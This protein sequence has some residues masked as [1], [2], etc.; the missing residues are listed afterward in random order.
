M[1]IHEIQQL[2]DKL[3]RIS[4]SL[5]ES[6]SNMIARKVEAIAIDEDR[7]AQ[8]EMQFGLTAALAD[9]IAKITA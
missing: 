4:E 2:A 7:I 6:V 9:D 3:A 1:A 8:A 5:H